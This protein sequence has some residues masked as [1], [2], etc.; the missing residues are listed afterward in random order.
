MK[1]RM[2]GMACGPEGNKLPGQEYEVSDAEGAALCAGRYAVP[3]PADVIERAVIDAVPVEV[4]V[5]QPRK[6][7]G[8]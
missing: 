2:I 4:R 5:D 6:R 1:I 3:V 7:R 8:R